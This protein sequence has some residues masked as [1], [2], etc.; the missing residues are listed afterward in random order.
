MMRIHDLVTDLIQVS[1]D[2]LAGPLP[3]T[4]NAPGK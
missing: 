1:L 2:L 4:L 3:D